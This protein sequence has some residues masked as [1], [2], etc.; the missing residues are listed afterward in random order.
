MVDRTDKRDKTPKSADEELLADEKEDSPLQEDRALEDEIDLEDEVL[1]AFTK[2]LT[3]EAMGANEGNVTRI[4][5]TRFFKRE[6]KKYNSEEVE[7]IVCC[8]FSIEEDGE[9]NTRYHFKVTNP[10]KDAFK[11]HYDTTRIGDLVGMEIKLLAV[12][13]DFG[14]KPVVFRPIAMHQDQEEVEF[15]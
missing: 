15:K 6:Q 10:V 8:N 1:S 12:K 3:P 5:P 11:K 14:Q 9:E 7:D 4:W 2:H 13:L